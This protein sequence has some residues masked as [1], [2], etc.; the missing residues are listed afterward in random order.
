MIIGS[1]PGAP[2]RAPASEQ[3]LLQGAEGGGEDPAI[4]PIPLGTRAPT[5]R[6]LLALLQQ[7]WLT[8]RSP[9]SMPWYLLYALPLEPLL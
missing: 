9:I 1:F 2:R 8:L 6:R 5:L 7:Q 4:L 3:I